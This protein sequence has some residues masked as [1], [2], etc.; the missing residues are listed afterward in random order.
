MKHNPAYSKWEDR[1]RFVLSKGH[2]YA[3][4]YSTLQLDKLTFLYKDKLFSLVGPSTLNLE[5]AIKIADRNKNSHLAEYAGGDR[6]GKHLW[7]LR[8]A[9]EGRDDM[10]VS[11]AWMNFTRRKPQILIGQKN[12]T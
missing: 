4:L 7:D 6:Q 2:A 8:G 11:G 1:D 5:E 9:R 3:L 10:A 12:L